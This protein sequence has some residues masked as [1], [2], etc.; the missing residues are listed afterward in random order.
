MKIDIHVHTKKVK[1]GDA[2]TREITPERFGKIIKLTDVRICAITIT[3]AIKYTSKEYCTD[4]FLIH[5]KT[6]FQKAFYRSA[7]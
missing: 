6:R 2:F 5:G 1:S 4:I 7:A 3:S